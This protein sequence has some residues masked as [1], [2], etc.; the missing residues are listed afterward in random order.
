MRKGFRQ[1]DTLTCQEDATPLVCLP[2]GYHTRYLAVRDIPSLSLPRLYIFKPFT[3]LLL[4]NTS[5][6]SKT[7][8]HQPKIQWLHGSLRTI[9]VVEATINVWRMIVTVDAIGRFIK[10]NRAWNPIM[11]KPRWTASLLQLGREGVTSFT[12]SF[13]AIVIIAV[14]GKARDRVHRCPQHI[15]I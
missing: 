11:T 10:V 12:P 9:S 3:H 2:W 4:D 7:I 15:L 1:D 13:H 14:I 8:H 6:L 5:S